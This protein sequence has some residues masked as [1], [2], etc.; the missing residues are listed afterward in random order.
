DYRAAYYAMAALNLVLAAALIVL[1]V[2]GSERIHGRAALVAAP[3]IAG[4]FP[5]FVTI[6]QGQSDLVVLVPLA[7]AYTAWVRGRIGWGGVF[8]RLPPV[9]PPPPLF[10]PVFF[11]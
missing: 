7:A 3:L 2:R 9:Q 8:T 5:L 4:F 6:L 1:L 10:V 11:L